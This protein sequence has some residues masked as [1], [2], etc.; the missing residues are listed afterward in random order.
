MTSTAIRHAMSNP[1]LRRSAL[2]TPGVDAAVLRKAIGGPA[3]VLIFDL[4]DAVAPERKAQARDTVA[5]LLA[6]APAAGRRIVVRVNALDTDWCAQ[7]VRAVAHLG[8][9]AIL[10]PKIATQGDVAR[11]TKLL[12]DAGAPAGTELWCMIE[13]PLAILNLLEI[14]RAATHADARMT[15]WVVGTNDL[16]KEMRG[17]HVP[18]REPLVPMLTTILLAA[19]AFDVRV[20]DG[21]HNDTKDA[22]GLA[23]CCAQGRAMGFDGKTLIH[24][25]QIKACHDAFSPTEAEVRDARRILEAFALPENQGKGVLNLDGRMVELLHAEMAQRTVAMADAIAD[26]AATSARS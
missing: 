22:D 14:A 7:D 4:E 1:P 15:T 5:Q 11:A 21:V 16:V 24:P 2:Y 26:A 13:T 6:Q 12:D 20:L 23:Q 17:R 8:P 18:G 3:D 19:R 9:S 10:F 25:N